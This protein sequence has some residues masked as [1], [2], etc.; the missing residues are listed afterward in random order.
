MDPGCNFPRRD[1]PDRNCAEGLGSA[2]CG[3]AARASSSTV[4]PDLNGA[5]VQLLDRMEEGFVIPEASTNELLLKV[6]L[7]ERPI[8]LSN[9]TWDLIAACVTSTS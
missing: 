3:R 7:P 5:L 2:A 9:F 8:H 4:A 1:D 6:R